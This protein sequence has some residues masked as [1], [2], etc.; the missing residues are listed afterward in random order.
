MPS[1]RVCFQ[2]GNASAA[3][4]RLVLEPRMVLRPAAEVLPC[5]GY[6]VQPVGACDRTGLCPCIITWCAVARLL[7]S[8]F[9]N[10][11]SGQSLFFSH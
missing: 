7:T 11:A 2:L 9:T 3:G 4:P 8:T 10:Q 5:Q 1:L 6:H